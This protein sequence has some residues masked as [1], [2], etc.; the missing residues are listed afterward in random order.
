M[1]DADRTVN[2]KLRGIH[3]FMITISGVL[4][5]GLYVRSGTILHIGGPAAVIIAFSAMGFLAW[6]VMQCIGE[7]LALW[8]ISGALTEYVST[9][10]D[11]EL[12]TA[13]GVTY[14]FTYSMNFAADIVAAAGV[15]EYWNPGKPVIGTVMFFLVPLFLILFNSFGVQ[16]YGLIEV[17]AGT[18]KL[19]GAIVVIIAMIIINVGVGSEGYIGIESRY[20]NERS[21]SMY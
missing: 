18:L 16:I 8:P 14:W 12:G 11:R 1:D 20:L 19:A 15:I 7:M 3:V 10:V 2:R 21:G 6:T 4:G 5:V 9:F 13:V 17:I